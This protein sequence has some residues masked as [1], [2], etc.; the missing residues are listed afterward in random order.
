MAHWAID[1]GTTNTVLARWD[2][3]EERPRIVRLK[4]VCRDPD[5][6]DPL[7]APGV[8][9][10]ATHMVDERDFWTSL[11]RWPFFSSRVFWGRHAI[12]GR[13]AVEK[14]VSTHHP[15]FLPSFKGHLQHQALKPVTRVGK[16]SFTARDV[17][18]AFVR[19]LLAEIERD[20]GE[21]IKTIAVTAPVDAYEGY[22][23]EVR[24]LFE[25]HGV[26]VTQFVDEPVAA[27]AGYGLSIR[28]RRQVLVVDFGGGTLDL[29]LIEIDAR[30][31]ESGTGKVI[32][33]AGRPIGGNVVDRW[34]LEWV[35]DKLDTRIPDDPFWERLLLD[36]ARWVKEQ[37]FLKES[38]P[39]QLRPPGHIAV[40]AARMGR[41]VPELTVTQND[42]RQLL[43]RKGM[44]RQLADV[45]DELTRFARREGVDTPPDD[46]LMVGGSTL[47]PGIFPHFEERF[48][49]D[50]VRAWHPFQAVVHGACSLSARG[51]APSD[52]IVHDYAIVTQD[53]DSGAKQTIP[54]VP[55]G[56]RFPTRPDLWRRHLVP[57]CSLGEPEREFRL[58]IC[59]IGKVR[60]GD[61]SFGWDDA[62]NLRTL[63]EGK[64]DQLIVPLNEANPALGF[65]DPPHPPGDRRARLDVQFG[66]NADRWLI[67]TVKDLKTNKILMDAEP[68]V[69]LL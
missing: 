64:D 30:T 28:D 33:K 9:P 37:V 65:L 8:V 10:S 20:T 40:T 49:R 53:L 51:F 42:L 6:H 68:V 35:C 63:G 36:E 29:A 48:G 59:E 34:L 46:V 57:S 54:I 62:G 39:F 21:R 5:G 23:A 7:A 52:Y 47:L 41:K 18:S 60:D 12:I 61:K 66:V 1:L 4:N 19:E 2:A 69:R 55:A 45:T 43:E 58:V 17:A 16:T 44:Y 67:A 15:A 27:A 22:R 31:V 24:Q 26:K 38:E 14:N 50:R 56:T 3:A 25:R 11:G 32:A 13:L